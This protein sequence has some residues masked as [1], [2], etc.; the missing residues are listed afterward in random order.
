M[1]AIFLLIIYTTQASIFKERIPRN[2]K[3]Q[4]FSMGL[5]SGLMKI[6]PR[7]TTSCFT[8]GA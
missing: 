4:E 8:D 5:S 6:Q 3:L 1:N 2:G 7:L